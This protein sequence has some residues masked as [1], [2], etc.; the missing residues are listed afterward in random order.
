M[1]YDEILNIERFLNNYPLISLIQLENITAY[2]YE[3]IWMVLKV[4]KREGIVILGILC[5]WLRTNK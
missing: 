4:N 3:L 1:Q 2:F 5:D